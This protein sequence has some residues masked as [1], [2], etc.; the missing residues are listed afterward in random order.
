MPSE[1]QDPRAE[2]TTPSASRPPQRI[3]AAIFDFDE[4]IIDLEPQHTG[5]Y[6]ALCRELGSD[7]QEMPESFRTGSGRRIIDDVRELRAHFGWSQ[8]EEEIFVV[9]QRIFDRICAESDLEAMAG[10]LETIRALQAR[11]IPL[12]ITSSSVRFSIETILTRLGIRDAFSLIVD[13]S[14]VINGKPDPEAYLVTARKLD[15]P[16][17]ECIVFEDSNVGVVAAKRAGMYCVA[18]RNPRA[19]TRQDLSAADVIVDSMREV[20]L[21]ALFGR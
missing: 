17:A 18:V 20:D 9:R 7:Y 19:Q 5:A 15:V 10:V 21:T 1:T 2:R 3:A 14:E 16:P 12:A 6:E 11:A 8:S 4:T 13:G